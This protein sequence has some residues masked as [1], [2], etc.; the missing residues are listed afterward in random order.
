[1]SKLTS[2]DYE[3]IAKAFI[4]KGVKPKK[5]YPML[6][7]AGFEVEIKGQLYSGI[8]ISRVMAVMYSI[9]GKGTGKPLKL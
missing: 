1:M 8:Y 4:N 9:K 7:E 2:A 3:I 5:V 6:E